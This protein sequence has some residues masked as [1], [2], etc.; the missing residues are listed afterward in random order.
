MWSG[1]RFKSLDTVKYCVYATL[2]DEASCT[3]TS[4]LAFSQ[5]SFRLAHCHSH[6]MH[7]EASGLD[8][9]PIAHDRITMAC[10]QALQCG[11]KHR[12][13]R[14]EWSVA[15][16]AAVP[17]RRR[18]GLGLGGARRRRRTQG[19]GT[20]PSEGAG[21]A[22]WSWW[23]SAPA[24]LDESHDESTRTRALLRRRR[25]RADRPRRVRSTVK[26]QN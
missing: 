10:G 18:T 26:R 22:C 6:S 3:D 17:A 20:S 1:K 25:W 19:R 11:R 7:Q 13:L 4:P 15:L 5:F 14:A 23:S 12:V 16:C 9:V 24:V 2:H 21:R 8:N